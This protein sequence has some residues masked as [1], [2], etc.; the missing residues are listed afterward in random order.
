[1]KYT[2]MD[3]AK[4][5][6]LTTSALHFYEKGKLIEVE[7]DKNNYRF[8]HSVD[9][10]R[11]LSYTK[12]RSMGFPM[13]TVVKQFG[14]GE[15]DRKIIFQRIVKQSEEARKKA[16]FYQDL[17]NSIDSHIASIRRIDDL[18]DKYEFTQSPHILFLHTGEVCGWISKDRREQGILQKW[19]KAMPATRLGAVLNTGE[20]QSAC[21]GY[22]IPPQ[23][24]QAL[25]LP[26]GLH[27]EEL[28]PAS[29]L[30]TIV[31]TDDRFS[32]NPHVAFEGAVE[33]ALSRGFA[34]SGKP[35]GYILL[36]EVSPGA[37]LKPYLELWIPIQ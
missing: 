14:G 21:L 37:K 11:L 20:A 10:F 25:T 35:W 13:K 24:A 34:I 22:A 36:V 9:I 18:L 28:H 32:D 5:L 26:L 4:I 30:H 27:S 3:V 6:G 12:Y 33:Y 17:A 23:K 31:A 2:V 16:A 1:M 8:Y 19:V 15:N 7:K 29:C